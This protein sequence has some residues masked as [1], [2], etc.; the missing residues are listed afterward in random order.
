ML[1]DDVLSCRILLTV[2]LL[3]VGMGSPTLA[4]DDLSPV[5]VSLQSGGIRDVDLI[6]GKDARPD[7]TL[8][9]EILPREALP[10]PEEGKL[11]IGFLEGPE[12]GLAGLAMA[13]LSPSGRELHLR[14]VAHGCCM[15][16][17]Y[18]ARIALT[19]IEVATNSAGRPFNLPVTVRV[20]R[21]F[22][23]GAQIAKV[24]G[25][26]LFILFLYFFS[27]NVYTQSYFISTSELARKFRPQK[28]DS[29]GNPLEHKRQQEAVL[30]KV[31][32]QLQGRFRDRFRAWL[33]A[34]PLRLMMPGKSYEETFRLRLGPKS[35][36]IEVAEPHEAARYKSNPSREKGVI[37]ASSTRSGVL[38]FGIP[39][40]N[41]YLS[42]LRAEP[43]LKRGAVVKL[44]GIK[45]LDP[46]P[47]K[48]AT[49]GWQV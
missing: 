35:L 3:V 8:R 21:K 28:W 36:S 16:G 19:P 25:G 49:E 2:L 17:T 7:L 24:V 15:N 26:T 5:E 48:D 44:R 11:E 29:F 10:W 23:Y 37:F 30:D 31:S 34:N 47:S 27:R 39:D 22:H 4:D 40:E 20:N 6:L 12:T 9:A 1:R 45:L 46:Y 42:G 38:L 32:Y 14:I 43:E 18:G 13:P 41:G 33:R